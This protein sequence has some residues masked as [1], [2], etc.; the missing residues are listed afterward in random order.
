MTMPLI[1][2]SHQDIA[3]N[4]LTYGRDYTRSVEVT[5]QLEAGTTTPER[6]GDCLVGWPEYQR[7]QV[8]AVFATLFAPPA[9]KKEPGDIVLYA[10][11]ETAYRLYRDQ[12]TVYRRLADSHPDKFRLVS[13]RTELDSVIAHW[14]RPIPE[15]EGHPVGLIYLMEGADGIRS[16]RELG[17]WY[18]QGLRIIGLAWAGTRY[19]GGTGEPGPLTDEGRKL[20]AAMADYNFILDLSHMDP[21]AAYEAL[22]RYEGP[23]IATHSNCAALMQEAETNRHIPD[24]VI[25]GLIERDGVIGLIPLNT[26]LKAGWLRKRGSRREEVPLDTYVAHIDHVCQLA[27]DALH[28]GIGSDFDG[29]FGLQSIPPELDTIADLQ[30]VATKLIERGY[31][32]ADAANVLGGNWLRILRTHLPV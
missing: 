16:P 21:A 9:R 20:I 29:G 32:G 25:R 22:D 10:D 13:S 27:G 3:W 6:N 14:S 23:L 30:M 4:M 11:Y 24:R 2:D 7:G 19:S 17:E 26:F 18:D 12:I 31:S 5:R 1:I 28:A 8:A 15:E